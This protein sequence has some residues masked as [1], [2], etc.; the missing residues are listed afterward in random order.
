MMNI[1]NLIE[2]KINFGAL[3]QTEGIGLMAPV[4]GIPQQDPFRSDRALLQGSRRQRPSQASD[5][6]GVGQR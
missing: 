1:M 2:L 4:Q 3:G 6:A 5:S